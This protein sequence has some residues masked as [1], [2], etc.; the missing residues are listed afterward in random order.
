MARDFSKRYVS[1]V[2]PAIKPD[3]S[4]LIRMNLPKRDELSFF[5]VLALPKARSKTEVLCPLD[6]VERLTFEDWV[7]LKQLPF[8]FDLPKDKIREDQN[9]RSAVGSYAPRCLLFERDR[10]VAR[11]EEETRV[12]CN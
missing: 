3:E 1:T 6:L 12:L 10:S 7:G 2:A 4:K 11:A 9:L 8:E 5:T